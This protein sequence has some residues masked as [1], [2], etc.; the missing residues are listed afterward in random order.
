LK[1]LRQQVRRAVQEGRIAPTPFDN[2]DPKDEKVGP[3]FYTVVEHIIK[4]ATAEAS[5]SWALLQHPE[6]VDCDLFVTH[7]WAEGIYEFIDKVLASWPFMDRVVPSWPFLDKVLP[8]MDKVLPSRPFRRRGAWIC[9]LSMPQNSDIAALICAPASSPFAEGLR[10]ASEVLVVPNRRV[11]VYTRLW[12]VYEAHLAKKVGK[13]IVTA[14]RSHLGGAARAV[15]TAAL[16]CP[17][18]VFLGKVSS[19]QG[20]WKDEHSSSW[21]ANDVFSMTVWLLMAVSLIVKHSCL[22]MAVNFLGVLV[23]SF[24]VAMDDWHKLHDI[25]YFLIAEVDRERLLAYDEEAANLDFKG[26]VRDATCSVATDAITIWNEIG[27]QISRVDNAIDILV[28]A[29]KCS[30]L[31]SGLADRGVDVTDAGFTE[32]AFLTWVAARCVVH[33]CMDIQI[34]NIALWYV[35]TATNAILTLWVVSMLFF[36]VDRRAFC[37]RGFQKAMS[38]YFVSHAMLKIVAVCVG[39]HDFKGVLH[40]VGHV[41]RLA[42]FAPIFV[43]CLIHPWQTASIPGIG[44]RLVEAILFRIR[45]RP[46]KVN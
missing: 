38:L 2:F 41:W 28:R 9:T 18:G 32:W 15:A 27:G 7:A 36:G 25:P 6:G 14:V 35:D 30:P 42:I 34:S 29:K 13:R 11:K 21:R 10:A 17:I 12:C 40:N 45:Q 26:S 1:D 22:R 3:S 19:L 31:L 37:M 8:Y 39:K 46:H 5:V 43:V 23:A 16:F 20:D 24:C 44:P 33:L 4:P